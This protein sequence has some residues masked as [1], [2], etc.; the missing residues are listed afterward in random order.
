M[1]K[2]VLTTM[3]VQAMGGAATP[4]RPLG[5]ALGQ[6]GVNIQDFVNQFN[7]A[8]QDRRGE[9]VPAV[10]TIYEDRSFSFILKTAPTAELV[11]KAAGIKSG[12]GKPHI[13]KVGS[14]TDAQLEEIAKVKMPDLNTTDVEMAKRIVAGTCRQMGVEI[15]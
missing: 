7:A 3:K 5:P 14:I 13:E 6:H 8:T 2:P 15:K 1:S 4:A 10:L 12:S 11:K 9:V